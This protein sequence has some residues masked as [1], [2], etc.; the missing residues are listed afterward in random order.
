VAWNFPH[1]NSGFAGAFDNGWRKY[2]KTWD[3]CS[4]P[5]LPSVK[6]QMINEI[7]SELVELRVIMAKQNLKNLW[8]YK[9][10]QAYTNSVPFPSQKSKR[11]RKR[12]N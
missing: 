4:L 7:H 2:Y 1:H 8:Y 9:I 6:V 5:N 11:K 10:I 3:S 12:K